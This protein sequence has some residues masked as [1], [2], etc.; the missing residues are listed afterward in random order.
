MSAIA[1]ITRV[2]SGA[3]PSPGRPSVPVKRS[4]AIPRSGLLRLGVSC[5]TRPVTRSASPGRTGAGQA[6]MRVYERGVG[7]TQS[8]GTG[9]CAVTAA[10]LADDGNPGPGSYRVTVP[11]GLLTV[12]RDVAGHLHL[13]GPAELVAHGRW[14]S[15]V[16]RRGPAS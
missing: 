7:E 10:L 9:A 14:D 3:A 4:L 8:C 6:S 15:E 11:G 13:K 2:L 16:P 1:L 12:S 5:S